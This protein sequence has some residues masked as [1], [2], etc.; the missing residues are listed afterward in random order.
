MIHT[1]IV[2]LKKEVIEELEN[3]FKECVPLPK[4]LLEA[5]T[6]KQMYFDISSELFD[7]LGEDAITEVFKS[8]II[9]ASIVNNRITILNILETDT[10]AITK[11]LDV[12]IGISNLVVIL[13]RINLRIVRN[14]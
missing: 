2:T 1:D 11:C 14:I 8:F 7:K 13:K 4:V 3:F 5:L 6:E 9:E 12:V 10:Y